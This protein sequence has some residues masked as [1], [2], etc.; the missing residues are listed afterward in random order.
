MRHP[1]QPDSDF[2]IGV[3]LSRIVTQQENVTAILAQILAGQ[4]RIMDKIDHLPP[5]KPEV[6]PIERVVVR[7]LTWILPMLALGGLIKW[8]DVGKVLQAIK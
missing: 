3:M 8:E 2:S 6:G 4:G 5:P 7:A 1:Q